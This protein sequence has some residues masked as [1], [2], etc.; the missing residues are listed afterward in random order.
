[1][2]I[3]ETTVRPDSIQNRSQR[4][5]P[6]LPVLV[7]KDS[8]MGNIVERGP[9]VARYLDEDIPGFF[10]DDRGRKFKYCGL[11]PQ[12]PPHSGRVNLEDVPPGH[13]VLTP[14]VLYA[15]VPGQAEKTSKEE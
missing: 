5:P 9:T 8:G 14:G 4:S 3:L 11:A 6:N 15:P 13:A 2:S 10:V 12:D 7:G 1:M